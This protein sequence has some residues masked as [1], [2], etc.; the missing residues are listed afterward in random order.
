MSTAA[1]DA[2]SARIRAGR[3][4]HDNLDQEATA[5]VINIV[6]AGQEDGKKVYSFYTLT[7]H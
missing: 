6:I 4:F 5:P 2:R 3:R 1:Q 7:I